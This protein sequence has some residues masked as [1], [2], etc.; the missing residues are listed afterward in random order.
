MVDV[1]QHE[2]VG[3]PHLLEGYVVLE[4]SGELGRVNHRDDAVQ[5]QCAALTA[6]ND[7]T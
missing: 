6:C 2:H 7:R 4:G 3:E 1:R 5:S